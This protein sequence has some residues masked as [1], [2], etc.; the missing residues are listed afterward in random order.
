MYIKLEKPVSEKMRYTDEEKEE[1]AM[2][3]LDVPVAKDM[4]FADLWKTRDRVTLANLE[5]GIQDLWY[6][7]RIVLV[8][9]SAHK[10]SPSLESLHFPPC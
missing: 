8:G 3:Y 4:V 1:V 9:D 10:V 5:E 2:R 6:D 7:G